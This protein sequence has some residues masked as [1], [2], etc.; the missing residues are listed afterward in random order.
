MEAYSMTRQQLF[1]LYEKLEIEKE[2]A[3][4]EERKRAVA[5]EAA[6]QK[7][8]SQKAESTQGLI[9]DLMDDDEDE[10]MDTEEHGANKVT[11]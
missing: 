1:E 8:E 4:R 7:E 2:I 3:D 6:R 10:A 9:N 11:T 5:L